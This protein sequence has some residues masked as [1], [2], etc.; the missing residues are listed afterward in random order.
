EATN[1]AKTIPGVKEVSMSFGSSAEFAGQDTFESVYNQAGV[2]F[3][4]ASGDVAAQTSYPAMSP[5]CVGVGGTSLNLNSSGAVVSETAWNSAGGNV[6]TMVAI[7]GWQ[8]R[9]KTSLG[10]FRGCPD[11]G[12]IADPNTGV[13]VY[14]PFAIGGSGWGQFGGTSLACPVVA[15]IANVRGQYS[16]S[17]VD[18]NYRYYS[19]MGTSNM[20]DVISGTSG[21]NTAG[22]GY[23]LITGVG[24]P[25]GLYTSPVT[26]VPTAQGVAFGTRV[27]GNNASL[28]SRDNNYYDVTANPL[29]T[30]TYAA[31]QIDFALG[32]FTLSK[33][34]D[35]TLDGDI[36]VSDK[37]AVLEVYAKDWTTG[38]FVLV[39]TVPANSVRKSINMTK[40]FPT[41]D[42]VSNNMVRL[43]IRA[44]VPTA[45]TSTLTMKVDRIKV[46]SNLFP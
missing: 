19:Q 2:V 15:A 42:W 14:C 30:N 29:S 11:I 26:I 38:N 33:L 21:G 3:F 8:Q 46:N 9:I 36:A 23:D 20:R 13:F 39:D 35:L 12:S 31:L 28:Q 1:Y 7:P 22:P 6:S 5:N 25:V 17:S 18:E 41:G 10:A 45:T 32:A 40:R 4:A 24:V 43:Q 16:N 34:S 44:T 37:R 27:T